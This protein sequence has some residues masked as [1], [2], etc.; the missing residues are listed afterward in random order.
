MIAA[1]LTLP[2]DN[3]LNSLEF[4]FDLHHTPKISIHSNK[5]HKNRNTTFRMDTS[6]SA[7]CLFDKFHKSRLVQRVKPEESD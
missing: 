7:P 2:Y 5:L 6:V 1:C 3:E 4:Y